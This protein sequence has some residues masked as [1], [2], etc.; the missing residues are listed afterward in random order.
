LKGPI[1]SL[2]VTY[3]VHATEDAS[4][5]WSAV[6]GLLVVPTEVGYERLEGHFGNEI[7]RA[8]LRLTGNEASDALK[9]LVEA[10]PARMKK[11]LSSH[12]EAYLDE[13]GTLF[14]RLDKQALVSGVLALGSADPVRFRV[15]PRLFLMKASAPQ[16]YRRLMGEF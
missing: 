2:E 7:L 9:R 5:I 6:A 3:L 14:L 13:H 16:F 1:Q 4:R 12:V 11:E 15:K 10:L 8:K